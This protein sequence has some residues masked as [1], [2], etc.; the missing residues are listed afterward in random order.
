MCPVKSKLQS[1]KV[2]HQEMQGSGLSPRIPFVF[3][4]SICRESRHIHKSIGYLEETNTLRQDAEH[5]II[6]RKPIPVPVTQ[7]DTVKTDY[8]YTRAYVAYF[9]QRPIDLRM[10]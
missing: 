9:L 7:H 6:I 8:C 4:Q 3:L 10:V 1:A 2:D 5:L